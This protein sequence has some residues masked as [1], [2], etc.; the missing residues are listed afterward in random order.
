ME[1][2]N[3]IKDEI[4]KLDIKSLPISEG[5]GNI[6]PYCKHRNNE[7]FWDEDGE[8]IIPFIINYQSVISFDCINA[9]EW[10]EVWKCEECE[11]FFLVIDN[12][13]C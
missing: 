1:D 2:I 4:S 11:K 6:C 13:D 7:E 8:P 3:S 12:G 10:D 9:H 5:Y